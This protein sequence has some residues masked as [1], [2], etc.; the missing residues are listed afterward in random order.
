MCEKRL[1]GIF[2][3]SDNQF[4]VGR[5]LW[6]RALDVELPLADRASGP[7][8]AESR[9]RIETVEF[10]MLLQSGELAGEGTHRST[11]EDAELAEKAVLRSQ[12]NDMV[13]QFLRV[14]ERPGRGNVLL[15]EER[16]F[17]GR[18]EGE[19]GKG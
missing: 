5:N 9:K 4:N 2:D 12:F 19:H 10:S 17:P 7:F 15:G 3:K 6:Q 18:L 11:F 13:S 14:E 1:V 8:L 16:A